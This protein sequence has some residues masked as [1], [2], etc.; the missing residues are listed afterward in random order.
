MTE[1]KLRQTVVA[2]MQRWLGSTRGDAYHRE[3]LAA[4]NSTSPLPRGYKMTTADHYCAATASAAYIKAGLAMISVVECSAS[5]MIELAKKKGIWVENDKHTPKPADIV[6]YDWQDGTNYASTDNKGVPDHV[7]IVET[8]DAGAMT[9]IEGNRPLGKVAR[10]PLQVNGRYIRGFICP[11]FKSIATPEKT[12]HELALEVIRG[13][14]GSG[15]TR[16]RR[17][18]EAGYDYDAVQAEVNRIL[19]EQSGQNYT[20]YVVQSGDTLS[21]IAKKYGTTVKKLAKDNAIS[22]VNLIYVGQKIKI[23]R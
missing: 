7:G 16:K 19:R 8:V 4:Y 13:K 2:W 10:H 23:Y 1:T 12:V 9:V 21:K 17:L 15:A 14:W 3:I 20:I 5:K 11:D 22:N 18:T 6:I